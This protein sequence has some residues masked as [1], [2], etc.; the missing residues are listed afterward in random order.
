MANMVSLS[1]EAESDK[2]SDA[3]II[4]YQNDFR[5]THGRENILQ[6][7]IQICGS[8]AQTLTYNAE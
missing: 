3:R 6:I 2:A 4:L 5:S 1:P 7:T 8:A